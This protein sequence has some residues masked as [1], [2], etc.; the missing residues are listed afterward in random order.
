M[1]I[2]DL[3]LVILCVFVPLWQ[4]YTFR[5][6]LNNYYFKHQLISL[7]GYSPFLMGLCFLCCPPVLDD[8]GLWPED[9]FPSGLL[10][11]R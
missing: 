11:P 4:N 2:N 3:K 5:S 7:K 6:G 9:V 1:I 8:F 10:P